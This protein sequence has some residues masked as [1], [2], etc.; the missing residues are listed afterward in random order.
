VGKSTLFNRLVGRRVAIVDS[1]PGV[2]RDRIYGQVE[3]NGR[4]FSLIDTAGIMDAVGEEFGKEL[5]D[6]VD[7]AIAQAD[8][9][10]FLVDA[11]DGPT[12]GD[13]ELAGYLRRTGKPVVV[14][15]NKV[16]LKART[17]TA[18][19]Q[20]WGFE[21]L[22]DISALR[23]TSSGDLLDL[24]VDLL[25]AAPGVDEV[26]EDAAV[27]LAIIGRPNVGKSSLVNKLAGEERMLVSDIA[28][29]TRDPVDTR[30]N[31]QGRELVLIDTAGL[32]RKM[33]HARG[34]DYYSLLRT[35]DCI[36]RC[37][38]AVMLIDA[39]Q[40]LQ[41]QE[42][43]VADMAI[44]A[45]K[46][47]VLAINKWD[48]ITEK[49]TNTAAGIERGIKADYP[50]LSHVPVIFISALTSQRLGKL[51]ELAVLVAEERRRVVSNSEI[52]AMLLRA[53]DKLQP[54]V[55]GGYRLQF[56]GGRQ[57]GN[58]PPVI[59]LFCN[60]PEVVPEHYRRFLQN[61]LR[62]EF[63]FT[64]TPV[65]MHFVRKNPDRRR[66]GSGNQQQSRKR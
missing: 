25:P 35:V 1:T 34:I 43:R 52:E 17:P 16:D 26:G 42:L 50:H 29:T 4:I 7:A 23:G 66:P 24:L 59:E 60:N 13:E 65:W 21:L 61:R 10:L 12:A 20:R 31:F 6:Q 46:G 39:Q 38:V 49:E 37:E 64:G 36:E 32:R 19:F 57:V 44:A 8:V 33:R 51:L 9:L 27:Q 48:L 5:R 30:I 41:R 40:G 54:P 15:I 22:M 11:G 55:V 58:T 28:G 2:T 45:G 53:M 63:P 56:Y 47:M 62:E 14:G 3:W 18:D